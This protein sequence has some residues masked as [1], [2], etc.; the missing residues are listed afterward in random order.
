MGEAGGETRVCSGQALGS[1][2]AEVRGGPPGTTNSICQAAPRLAP[3]TCGIC[4]HLLFLE[5]LRTV[6]FTVQL[7]AGVFL[8]E[9]GRLREE[10]AQSEPFIKQTGSVGLCALMKIS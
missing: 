8:R 4:H 3:L 7:Q 5:S 6:T 1:P 2:E 9:K 10:M